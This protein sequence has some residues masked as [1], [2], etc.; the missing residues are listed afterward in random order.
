MQLQ[1]DIQ[2]FYLS[3]ILTSPIKIYFILLQGCSPVL[4]FSFCFWVPK[5]RATI[6]DKHI[7]KFFYMLTATLYY[8]V[9]L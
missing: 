6:I 2:A 3:K 8:A 5:G 4:S 7:N 1:V 9:A